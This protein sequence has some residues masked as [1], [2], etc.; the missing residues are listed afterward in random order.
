MFKV[1]H[2]TIPPW[3]LQNSISNE[4]LCIIMNYKRNQK[5]L[6][7]FF[8]FQHQ[9]WMVCKLCNAGLKIAFLHLHFFMFEFFFR[10]LHLMRALLMDEHVKQLWPWRVTI[11][12]S[13]VK[14]LKKAAKKMLKS[15]VSSA[16]RALLFKWSVKMSF[17][18]SFLKG[19]NKPNESK[20]DLVHFQYLGWNK[21]NMNSLNP[22]ACK[23]HLY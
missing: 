2:F 18:S 23:F 9:A 22:K 3:K 19:S 11:R 16:T 6:R 1:K 12:W 17:L 10:E 20:I 8:W 15:S 7:T 14:R 4:Y 21:I 13:Q 5:L